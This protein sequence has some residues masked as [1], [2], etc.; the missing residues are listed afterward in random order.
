MSRRRA[1]ACLVYL[2]LACAQTPAR[3]PPDAC[4]MS[5]EPDAGTQGGTD[6]SLTWIERCPADHPSR[7][8][9]QGSDFD[10][11]RGVTVLFGGSTGGFIPGNLNDTW[12]WD[13]TNWT[14][15]TPAVSPSPRANFGMA[16]DEV[17]HASVL[18]AGAGLGDGNGVPQ[19]DTWE[20]DGT[21]WTQ[22]FPDI[23][24]PVRS[25][26]FVAYDSARQVV[27]LF[28][29]WSANDKYLNDTWEWNGTT[30]TQR[31]PATSPPANGFG[32]Y[33][34]YDVKRAVTLLMRYPNELW[35][36]DGTSWA[37]AAFAAPDNMGPMGLAYDT[38]RN[39]TVLLV[40]IST[41]TQA[42]NLYSNETWQWDGT[43]LTD[44]PIP[45]LQTVAGGVSFSYDSRRA[46]MVLFG[47]TGTEG[48]TDRTWELLGS[49]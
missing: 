31:L 14:Q 20:W 42:G 1:A 24:P 23:S 6:G 30:W 40:D 3:V 5:L 43:D 8:A 46:A 18:V 25:G 34:V 16:Y 15:R 49:P 7:R 10:S 37:T 9:G 12:E 41:R 28:G 36:W 32:Q 38:R 22:K 21:N 33:M 11:A 13:G 29:G 45:T 27:V 48:P 44:T 35:E 4:P 2:C 39:V 47:G 26:P 17:R 19:N